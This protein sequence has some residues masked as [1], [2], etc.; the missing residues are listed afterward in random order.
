MNKIQKCLYLEHCLLY[1][2]KYKQSIL[3]DIPLCYIID[4]KSQNKDEVRKFKCRYT[5]LNAKNAK[6]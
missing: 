5:T 4:I 3:S 6:K 2:V 1:S